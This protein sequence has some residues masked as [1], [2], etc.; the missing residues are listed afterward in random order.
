MGRTVI[1]GDVHSCRSE[2]ESL[3]D[4]MGFTSSD[5]LY[6]C[7]DLLARGPDGP[8]V[9]RILRQTGAR[10]VVGNHEQRLLAAW[11]A[12]QNGQRGPRLGPSHQALMRELSDQD[13]ELLSR[14]PLYL[15]LPEHGLRL[16]HAGVVPG[17]PI[18]DQDP[19]VLT[20]IRSLNPD[21]SPSDRV[22]PRL[23]GESYNERPHVVF[24]HHAQAGLQL[25]ACATGLD[26]GCVYG[27]QLT[28]FVL[29]PGQAPPPP[30]QRRESMVS[31]AARA[32]YVSFERARLERHP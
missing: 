2:L 21:G 29:Q 14:L 31:V 18:E 20:H 28:A 13:F 25:H 15:D 19:W 23:W 24:G 12:R 22:R 6:F 11:V 16:V 26:T 27:G 10:S 1:V 5:R 3:L 9:L 7:G 4:R 32:R 17:V 30:E 8:G